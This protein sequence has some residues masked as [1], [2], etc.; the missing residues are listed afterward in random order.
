LLVDTYG[1]VTEKLLST[2]LRLSVTN[3]PE[4]SKTLY[5]CKLKGGEWPGSFD[6]KWK[7]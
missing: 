3:D 5:Q 7:K 2:L 4:R 1:S 6:G